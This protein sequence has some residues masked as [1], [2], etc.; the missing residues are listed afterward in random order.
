MGTRCRQKERN[1]LENSTTQSRY[2]CQRFKE[3]RNPIVQYTLHTN[4]NGME[5]KKNKIVNKIL[6]AVFF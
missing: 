5:K 2:N 3:T 6:I 4:K 1:N